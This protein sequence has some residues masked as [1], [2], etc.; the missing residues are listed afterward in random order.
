MNHPITIRGFLFMLVVASSG[1]IAF[2]GVGLLGWEACENTSSGMQIPADDP[3]PVIQ[4]DNDL[5][6]VS[7]SP[8][9]QSSVSAIYSTVNKLEINEASNPHVAS[10]D[11][12]FVKPIPIEL[13]KIPI[14]SPMD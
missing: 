14:I 9:V 7:S 10:E 2:A 13:L 4:Q 3:V 1:N 8:Q 6:V 11:C 5:T 12:Y